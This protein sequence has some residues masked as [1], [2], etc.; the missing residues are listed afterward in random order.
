MSSW[1]LLADD[2][3][4]VS[5]FLAEREAGGLAAGVDGVVLLGGSVL[6]AAELAFQ[7]MRDGV[8][9]TLVIVGGI[10]HATPFLY[11][12]VAA[13]PRYRDVPTAGRSEAEILAEI[14][15]RHWQLA[16][17]PTILETRSTNCG[18]NAVECRRVLAAAGLRPAVLA[19][20]QDPTM[21][22]RTHATF[23]CVWD[24]AG[25]DAR[26]VSAPPFVPRVAATDDGVHFA[27]EAHAAWPMPRFLSLLLGE[28]PRLRDDEAGY[29]PRGRGFLVHV[30]IPDDV[31]RAH[32][33]LAAQVGAA[34]PAR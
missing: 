19:L 5:D 26:L 7:A 32:A 8:A 29:G 18:E 33:R 17:V 21:Q 3:N 34:V 1:Q 25:D 20:V 24:A 23:R 22:R 2:V 30:A 15:I 16:G 9:R 11:D 31:L 13:H 14:A 27:D 4:L 10:G 28:I 6:A 12:A